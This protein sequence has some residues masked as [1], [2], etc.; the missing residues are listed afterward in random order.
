MQKH[1]VLCFCKHPEPGLVKTRLAENLG[2]G[3]AAI[4]YKRILEHILKELHKSSL[5]VVLCCYPDTNH[6]FFIYCKNEYSLS[7]EKQHGN[8]LGERMYNSL[9][10]NLNNNDS[11]VLIGSDCPQLDSSYINTAFKKLDSGHDIVLGPAF[12]GG[13]A[14]I[15]AKRIDKSIFDDIEWSRDDVL[16]HTKDRI[17]SLDWSVN[18]LPT[19][20][21][22]DCLADYE[23]YSQ[24]ENFKHLFV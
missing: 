22:I 4:I 11:V 24:Q 20:R 6:P 13:Y 18:C 10:Y 8:D 12:D 3:L 19:V 5:D 9:K 2:K 14:L 17:T 15:G 16:L 1:I 23:Y 21:D 7:L